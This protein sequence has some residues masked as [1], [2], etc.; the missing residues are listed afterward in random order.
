[1]FFGTQARLLPGKVQATPRMTLRL[2]R[3]IIVGGT[4]SWKK[5][6]SLRD[7]VRRGF[8]EWLVDRR[9]SSVMLFEPHG[10]THIS[11]N[12]KDGA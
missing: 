5:I 12:L 4:S 6:I 11:R 1:M 10:T 2:S 3:V 7:H 8:F 9:F